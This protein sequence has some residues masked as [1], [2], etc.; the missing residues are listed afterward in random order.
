VIV[1]YEA[2]EN[3]SVKIRKVDDVGKIVQGLGTLGVTDLNGPNFA[4]DNEDGLKAQAQKLAIDD[5]KAKAKVLAGNLGVRLGKITSFNDNNLYSV[6]MYA[7]NSMDKSASGI[8]PS[9]APAV[10]PAGENLITSDVTLT[11]EIR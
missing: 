3:I 6:P 2:Y 9:A 10:V 4:I 1:G 11:Y 5:A 7:T 8:A